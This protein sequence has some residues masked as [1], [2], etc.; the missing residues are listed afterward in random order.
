MIFL[1]HFFSCL[2]SLFLFNLF[3]LFL[4]RSRLVFWRQ[5]VRIH[6]L[7]PAL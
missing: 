6:T 5:V 4:G 3:R 7:S 1:I 2:F